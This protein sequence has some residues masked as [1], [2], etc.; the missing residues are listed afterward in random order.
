VKYNLLT[1]G[2]KIIEVLSSF[3]P[4][5][6]ESIFKETYI[7][8]SSIYRI[9]NTLMELGYVYKYRKKA[10]DLWKLDLKI[11]NLFSGILSKLDIRNEIKDILEHLAEETREVVELGILYKGKVMFLDVIKKHESL[12]NVPGIGAI[13]DI[14]CCVAGIVLAAYLDEEQ[15]NSILNKIDFTQYTKYTIRNETGIRAEL[16]EAKEKGYAID[17]QWYAIGHRC[18]GAP[19][20]DYTGKVV[21]SINIAGHISSIKDNRIDELSK[22]VKKSAR[23]A[24]IRL[25]YAFKSNK[26]VKK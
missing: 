9:L 3:G 18:I 24:S 4:L 7:S 6:L 21:A 12:I 14:N 5:S 11:L 25:G 10:E 13:A 26:S 17:D 22:I 1:K 23:K 2:I 20:F 15:L 19:I 16:K 8:R